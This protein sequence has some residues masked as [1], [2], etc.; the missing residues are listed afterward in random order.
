MKRL[1]HQEIDF[2][3]T[4]RWTPTVSQCKE[5]GRTIFENE[6]AFYTHL[7]NA[8]IDAEIFINKFLGEDCIDGLSFEDEAAFMLFCLCDE[9]ELLAMDDA[10]VLKWLQDWKYFFGARKWDTTDAQIAKSVALDLFDGDR[11]ITFSSCDDIIIC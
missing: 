6:T 9:Q 1:T 7:K 3:K 10:A 11:E 4:T 2:I 8:G 5:W